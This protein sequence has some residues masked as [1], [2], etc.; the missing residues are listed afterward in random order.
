MAGVLSVFSVSEARQGL[1]HDFGASPRPRHRGMSLCARACTT[2]AIKSARLSRT[3]GS[4]GSLL[5]RGLSSGSSS[6]ASPAETETQQTQTTNAAADPTSRFTKR[7]PN[8]R[9]QVSNS[10]GCRNAPHTHTRLRT[11][12]LGEAQIKSCCTAEPMLTTKSLGHYHRVQAIIDRMLRVDH[13]GEYGAIRIYDG[14][15]AVLGN[16]PSAP[17][18]EEMR[19]QEQV[20][21]DTLSELIPRRR[22][23]PSLLLPIWNIAGYA[24]GT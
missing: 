8:A 18:I 12:P 9:Q 5:L 4:R 21:L 16:A 14:Q 22:V 3:L 10:T 20:H 2:T 17:V 1:L 6:S 11:E 19:Q 24:L 13:A 15:L 7:H 23:R